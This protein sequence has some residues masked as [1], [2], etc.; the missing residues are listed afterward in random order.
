MAPAMWNC[1]A[2]WLPTFDDWYELAPGGEVTWSEAWYPVAGIGGVTFAND[3]AALALLPASGRLKVGLF[4]TTALRGRLT[5]ILPGMEPSVR[6]VTI[7]P[8]QPLVQE[9]AL[10]EGVPAQGQVAVT[11]VDAQGR[12]L[13]EWQGQAALR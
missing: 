12:T 9:V 10:A 8:A 7:S 13:F 1:T 5:V 3:A 2:A 4:P 11:L 6:E